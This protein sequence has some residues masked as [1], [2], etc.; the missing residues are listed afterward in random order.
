MQ[1]LTTKTLKELKALAEANLKAANDRGIYHEGDKRQRQTWIGFLERGTTTDIDVSEKSL[2]VDRA[3]EPIEIQAQDTIAPHGQKFPRC[4]SYFDGSR[5]MEPCRIRRNASRS[6]RQRP[7]Q[8]IGMGRHE[9]TPI[10]GRLP[11]SQQTFTMPTT[12]GGLRV[13]SMKFLQKTMRQTLQELV[14]SRLE[15]MK[16]RSLLSYQQDATIPPNLMELA[17]ITKM[18]DWEAQRAIA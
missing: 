17:A 2:D 10:T 8:S 15:R 7:A 11:L 13:K 18:K 16:L 12:N 1:D 4:Q 14:P 3:K 9:R 6:R 5:R